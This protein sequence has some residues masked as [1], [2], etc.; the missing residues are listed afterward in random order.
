MS[1]PSHK[2]SFD[3]PAMYN[4][5]MVL[6][7]SLGGGPIRRHRSVTPARDPIRRPGTANSNEFNPMNSAPGSV[8][9][10]TSAAHRGYHPYASGYT[11]S[12]RGG[13]AH[14]SPSVHSIPLGSDYGHMRSS[15]RA[16][17]YGSGGVMQV[18]EQMKHMMTMSGTD[19]AMGNPEAGVGFGEPF[20]RTDSPGFAPQTESPAPFT[21]ELPN[22]FGVHGQGFA[23]PAHSATMP[24]QY[25]QQQQQQQQ[26]FDAFYPQHVQTL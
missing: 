21:I 17:N 7:D 10:N 20:L 19:V 16:S 25:P 24:V 26:Q 2:A 1:A 6:D 13:S 23:A 9:S 15:S 3:H 22:Q 11:S 14:S 5:G 8:G 4:S 18:Q 12:S